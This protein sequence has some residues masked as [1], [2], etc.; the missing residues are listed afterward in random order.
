M[1]KFL[2][3]LLRFSFYV[4]VITF[5]CLV[6]LLLA[7]LCPF[8]HP[9]TFWPLPFF[10]L[11]YPIILAL[12]LLLL[13]YWILARS[14]WSI[15]VLVVLLIG[16]KLHFR[17]LAMGTEKQEIPEGSEPFHI[18]SYNVRLFDRYSSAED[19]T[20][21]NRLSI[22]KYI[23]EENPD[24]ICFQEFY[25]QDKPTSFP[26]R[27]TLIKL[28]GIKDFHERYSHKLKGRQNFGIAT[29]SKYP[30]IS[31]GDVRIEGS[32]IDDNYCIYTDIVKNS[33]TIRVYNVHLQSIKFK[34]ADYALFAG[35][36]N[37]MEKSKSAV[38]FLIEKLRTAYPKRADQALIVMEHMKTSPYPVVVCGDF[39]DTPMSYSYN[40]FNQE[41]IDAFRNT[42]KGVGSTYVGRIPA[43]RIDYI[44]HSPDLFSTN[45]KIQKE[46]Y[47]DHRAISCEIYR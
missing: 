41:L 24:I 20:Q 44:F 31:K 36:V 14:G 5:I 27:D 10:G 17:M 34:K 16:G 32:E 29:L 23:Q 42:R 13:I 35:E 43:G 4:K 30:M 8:I 18:M 6:L 28:L 11:A 25:H 9:G 45:F 40:Q 1:G 47:S 21:N 39:N 46:I 22:F 3:A 26:T 12:T 2:K 7:Y 38:G 15:L 19:P 37:T 33:D